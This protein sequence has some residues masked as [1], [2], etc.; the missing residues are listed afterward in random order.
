MFGGKFMLHM[1]CLNLRPF[2]TK[3]VRA[4]RTCMYAPG[5]SPKMLAKM[6]TLPADTAMLDLEDGVSYTA[7]IQARQNIIDCLQ[8]RTTDR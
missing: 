7:K 2:S 3:I 8:T 5:S 6:E 1:R 4:R